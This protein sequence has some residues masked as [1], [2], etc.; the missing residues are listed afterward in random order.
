MLVVAVYVDDLLISGTSLL[1]IIKF[2]KEMSS[3]FDMSDLGRLSYY[4]GLE[5]D[6][7]DGYIKLKQRALCKESIRKSM[8]G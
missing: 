5:V 8:N 2:K 6:R 3:I 7:R 4:V 1:N